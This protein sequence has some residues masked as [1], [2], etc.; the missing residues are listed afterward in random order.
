MTNGGILKPTFHKFMW[1]VFH[2][3]YSYITTALEG[4]Q[5]FVQIQPPVGTQRVQDQLAEFTVQNL[6]RPVCMCSDTPPA[7]VVI[8]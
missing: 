2:I 3:Q 8:A 1:T 6:L 4:C 7:P 5:Y